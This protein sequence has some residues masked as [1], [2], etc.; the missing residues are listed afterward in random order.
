M[1]VHLQY[2]YGWLL[3]LQESNLDFYNVVSKNDDW[4]YID[5]IIIIFV[6]IYLGLTKKVL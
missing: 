2:I 4:Y 3:S 1:A 6:I 5:I